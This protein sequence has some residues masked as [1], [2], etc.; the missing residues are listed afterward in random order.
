MNDDNW[1][2]IAKPVVLSGAPIF[3]SSDPIFISG[4][5]SAT[6]YPAGSALLKE[7][8]RNYNS[9]K[10]LFGEDIDKEELDKIDNLAEK[11]SAKKLFDTKLL[12]YSS[13]R[14]NYLILEKILLTSI[15]VM[16]FSLPILL[17]VEN[18]LEN[19][20]LD[21]IVI[22]YCILGVIALVSYFFTKNLTFKIIKLQKTLD[23]A[24]FKGQEI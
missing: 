8:E 13:V 21:A 18:K 7:E 12:E 16:I 4:E 9:Y 14:T 22:Y 5:S 15:M 1:I 3:S 23:L 6:Y 17:F 20:G 10:E 11:K 2:K 19:I 24:K